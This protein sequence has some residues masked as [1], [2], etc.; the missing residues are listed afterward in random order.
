MAGRPRKVG[1]PKVE[2]DNKNV[3]IS[4]SMSPELNRYLEMYCERMGAS[5]SKVIAIATKEWLD[6]QTW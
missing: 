1:R 6:S 3:K 4:I 5:K 2:A